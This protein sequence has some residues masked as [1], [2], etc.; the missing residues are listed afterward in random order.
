MQACNAYGTTN[1]MMAFRAVPF[2]GKPPKRL[3]SSCS[4]T[5]RVSGLDIR[6]LPFEDRKDDKTDQAV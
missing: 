2:S 4:F 3:W 1:V 5:K 6:A